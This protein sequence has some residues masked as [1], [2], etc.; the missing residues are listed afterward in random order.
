MEII[1]STRST[2]TPDSLTITYIY[3]PKPQ[4]ASCNRVYRS[5]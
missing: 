5:K 1:L 2:T 4:L 3:V